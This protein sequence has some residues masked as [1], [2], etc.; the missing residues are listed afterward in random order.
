MTI[1]KQSVTACCFASQARR[2]RHAGSASP[3][4]PSELKWR[5]K[6]APHI[7]RGGVERWRSTIRARTQALTIDVQASVRRLADDSYER[8]NNGRL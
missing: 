8:Q 2:Y 4:E 5:K 6:R 3:G 7:E 1:S